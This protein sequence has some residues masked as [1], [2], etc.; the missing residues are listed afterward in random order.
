MIAI[1]GKSK[2][3]P[4]SNPQNKGAK[5]EPKYNLPPD[6]IHHRH[7]FEML[8]FFLLPCLVLGVAGDLI[9]NGHAEFCNRSYGV[10]PRRELLTIE[11]HIHRRS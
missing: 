9:C 1:P 3:S 8:T 5:Y 7:S 4:V 2:R 10:D 11:Y 6:L